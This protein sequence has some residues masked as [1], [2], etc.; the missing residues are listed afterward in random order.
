MKKNK[1]L[2]SELYETKNDAITAQ[3]IRINLLERENHR[4]QRKYKRLRL[5]NMA[6][7]TLLFLSNI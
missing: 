4:L 7:S 2:F 6:L 5:I 1:P 3:R